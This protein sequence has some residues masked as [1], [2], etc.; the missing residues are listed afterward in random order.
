MCHE[1]LD[2]EPNKNINFLTGVNSSGKSSVL[3]GLVLGL[4]G[5]T[6]QTKRYRRMQDFIQKGF[7]RAIV[8]VEYSKLY[9]IS[10]ICVGYTEE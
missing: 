4:L 3:Q 6:K 5:D 2:W 8:Q 7:S 10:H 9:F 1:K